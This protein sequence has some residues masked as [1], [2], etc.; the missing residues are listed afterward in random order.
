MSINYLLFSVLHEVSQNVCHEQ[1]DMLGVP[2][3]HEISQNTFHKQP[4]MH[5][6]YLNIIFY[7]KFA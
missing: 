6:N 5:E 7:R 4:H 3:L 1:P 2:I